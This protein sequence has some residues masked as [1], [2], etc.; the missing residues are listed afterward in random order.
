MNGM[1]QKNRK[2][3]AIIDKSLLHEVSELPK[4]E[5]EDFWKLLLGKYF[6]V[7]PFILLEEIIVN[8]IRGMLAV[9][10]SRAGSRL[11]ARDFTLK[12]RPIG[13]N[14]IQPASW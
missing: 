9:K 13:L 2:S 6:V 3:T 14:K 5:R 7:V 8:A 10:D 4:Q 1:L 11:A 12:A